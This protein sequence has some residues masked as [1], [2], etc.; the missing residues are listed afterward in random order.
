MLILN[1]AQLSRISI[2]LNFFI[3]SILAVFTK[4]VPFSFSTNKGQI[5]FQDA[6]QNPGIQM[7]SFEVP[8]YFPE[9]LSISCS[10]FINRM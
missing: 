2:T 9:S 1:H 10:V 5:S 4:T 3:K 7:V 6:V 8:S